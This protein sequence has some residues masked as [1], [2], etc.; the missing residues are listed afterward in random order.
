ML[1]AL[2]RTLL[3]MVGLRESGKPPHALGDLHR[4]GRLVW[5]PTIEAVE[6]R[7]PLITFAG[8]LK[9]RCASIDVEMV[10]ACLKR[11]AGRMPDNRTNSSQGDRHG[12]AWIVTLVCLA[13][14]VIL[15]L[16]AIVNHEPAREVL[17]LLLPVI[18]TWVGTIL[19]FY[20]GTANF[21]AASRS[22]LAIATQLTPSE[23]LRSQPVSNKM[24]QRPAMFAVLGPPE[25]V[26]L[27]K[28]L[29]DLAQQGKGERVPVLDAN[30]HPLYVVHR[31]AIDR[32][33]V[34]KARSTSNADLNTLT[35]R[36]MLS[37]DRIGPALKVS[38]GT[39]RQDSTLADAKSVMD[40]LGPACQDVFVTKEGTKTEPVLG[41]ITNNIIDDYAKV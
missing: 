4:F 20:F 10:P 12:I 6:S 24:I 19:A 22:A 23:R 14:V 17:T 41:W 31:S 2:E 36:D 21:E 7:S 32:F 25:N 1:Q 26:K 37:D 5:H 9:P 29:D 8:R 11:G 30:D 15:G 40:A 38:F 3:A 18:G 16:V 27:A 13:G 28:T 39:V 34:E 33:I 35:L